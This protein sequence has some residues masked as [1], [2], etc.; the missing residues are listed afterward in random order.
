MG[1]RDGR[2]SID[3]AG[4]AIVNQMSEEME[5]MEAA[6]FAHFTITLL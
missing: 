6:G 4:E 1:Q 3:K 5:C 2:D